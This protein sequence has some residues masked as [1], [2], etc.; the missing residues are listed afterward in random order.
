M[1]TKNKLS[2]FKEKNQLRFLQKYISHIVN[3]ALIIGILS[4]SSSG[5]TSKNK[6]FAYMYNPSSTSLHPQYLVYHKD[7]EVS[8]LMIKFYPNELLFNQTNEDNEYRA[9][10]EFSYILTDVEN[11]SLVDS[12][13]ILLTLNLDDVQDE[14]ITFIP[15]MAKL[16]NKYKLQVKSYDVKRK[17]SNRTAII[18]DKTNKLSRQNFLIRQFGNSVPLFNN[19]IDSNTSFFIEYTYGKYDSLNVKY[20]KDNFFIPSPPSLNVHQVDR[21]EVPDSQYVLHLSDTNIFKVT[22]KGFYTFQIDTSRN[23]GIGLSYFGEDYPYFKRA[24]NL[25]Y[26]LNYLMNDTRYKKLLQIP[27]KKLAVDNYWLNAANDNI[28]VARELI[29]VY[30]NRA[31]LANYYFTSYKEGWKTDRGM[32]YLIYGLPNYIY[33]SD[34]TERWIYEELQGPEKLYFKFKKVYNPYSDENYVLMRSELLQTRWK[35]AISSWNS[36]KPYSFN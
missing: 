9:K 10:V 8:T 34:D 17:K 35:D 25:V 18:V 1:E 4:C 13:F 30:Y 20:Y 3:L 32:I 19:Q 16:G 2:N 5:K 14:M 6:N 29:R 27:N 7:E 36:G 22:K 24:D 23:N 26:P 28:E 15:F 21:F 31:L 12:S 33:K 11:K